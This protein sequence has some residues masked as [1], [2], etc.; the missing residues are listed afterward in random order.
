MSLCKDIKRKYRNGPFV[1]V[2]DELVEEAT[3]EKVVGKIR[4]QLKKS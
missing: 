3:Y 4:E 1:F 2:N